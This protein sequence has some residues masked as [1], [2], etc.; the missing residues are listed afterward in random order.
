MFGF[1]SYSNNNERKREQKESE[2]ATRKR[3]EKGENYPYN[4]NK[5]GRHSRWQDLKVP[6][7]TNKIA[8]LRWKRWPIY[9][10]R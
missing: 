1:L 2:N 6:F 8:Y 10:Q 3:D 5:S 9:R 7:R 4:T